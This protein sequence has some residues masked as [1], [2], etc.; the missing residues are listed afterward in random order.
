VCL[1][2][3]E[4]IDKGDFVDYFVNYLTKFLEMYFVSY[5]KEKVFE[6]KKNILDIREVFIS[7]ILAKYPTLNN[8]LSDYEIFRLLQVDSSLET[9]FY[10]RLARA[11]YMQDHGNDILPYIASLMRLK[12]G[13]EVYYSTE[14]GTGF[15]IMHGTGVVIGPRHKIGNNFMI[16]QGVTLGQ[17]N[18]NSPNQ[19]ITIG[20][21][22]RIFAGAK[23]L[24]TLTIGDNVIIG[25]NAVLLND[26]DSNST[27]VGI[28]AKN[29]K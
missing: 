17:K 14:I 23:I 12:T 9:V 7:D 21:N 20:N 22:V 13:A 15:I 28:P 24:G 19:S 8:N 25:A 5:P 1:H 4:T 18:I 10:Y 11:I 16:Y 3:I 2:T 26:A 6:L 29:V 27:Y